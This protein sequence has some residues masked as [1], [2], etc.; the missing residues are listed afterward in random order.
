M[1]QVDAVFDYP[2]PGD[3]GIPVGATLQGYYEYC[4]REEI[5]P[6][7]VRIGQTYYGPSFSN[8]SIR[9]ILINNNNSRNTTD[10]LVDAGKLKIRRTG[11]GGII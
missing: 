4:I 11:D 7:Q 8:E 6:Q 2:A 3:G 5:T 1:K 10:G 9:Q